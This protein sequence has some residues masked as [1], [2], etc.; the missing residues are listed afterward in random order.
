MPFLATQYG[1]K[2]ENNLAKNYIENK[3]HLFRRKK[4]YN[5]LWSVVSHM[6]AI[7]VSAV[8]YGIVSF[9]RKLKNEGRKL[10]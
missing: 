4:K 8:T 9:K 1:Y 6:V 3:M 7:A 5:K 10:K 2:T